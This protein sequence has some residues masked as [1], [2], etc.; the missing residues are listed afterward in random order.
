MTTEREFHRSPTSQLLRHI[1]DDRAPNRMTKSSR[2]DA[3]AH[4]EPSGLVMRKASRDG[5]GV[6]DGAEALVSSAAS[7]SGSALPAMLMRKFESSLDADLSSVRIHTGSDS[8]AAAHAVGARAYTIGQDIHFAAGQYDPS[9]AGGEHLLAHEV[10]H[11]V[12]QQGGSTKRQHKLEVSTPHDAAEHEADCAADA[13]VSGHSFVVT[14]GSGFQRKVFRDANS[15]AAQADSKIWIDLPATKITAVKYAY[16]TI[17]FAIKGKIGIQFSNVANNGK[18]AAAPVTG[19]TVFNSSGGGL[20]TEVDLAKQEFLH[21]LLGLK[22]LE[23][24]KEKFSFELSADQFKATVGMESRVAWEKLPWLQ[25]AFDATFYFAAVK[26]ADLQ[27]NPN[28]IKVAA[29]ESAI[30]LAGEGECRG[31]KVTSAAQLV[32][33]ASPN[34]ARIAAEAVKQGARSG[35]Q[36]AGATATT[37]AAVTGGT[38]AAL[39]AGMVETG[40]VVSAAAAIILPLAVGAAMVAGANQTGKNI[41]ASRA[42][43]AAGIKMRSE[44]DRYVSGYLDAL[45]GRRA[46]GAGATE[47][48]ATLEAYIAATGKSREQAGADLVSQNGGHDNLK[49]NLTAQLRDRLYADAVKWF[50]ATFAN[51]FGLLEKCGET[52]GMRGVFRKDLYRVL[53]GDDTSIALDTEPDPPTDDTS[54]VASLADA[55]PTG[56]DG[57]PEVGV[58]PSGQVASTDVPQQADDASFDVDSQNNDEAGSDYYA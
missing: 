34:W 31:A 48:N 57:P 35:A 7:S 49:A 51:Q 30:G 28:S 58:D 32:C 21:S 5:N 33:T 22:F 42:A 2:L 27:Q 19:G 37:T 8:A 10:A 46:T 39:V 15:D 24:A 52:W 44:V 38:D 9:S 4:P 55:T 41:V 13:M 56:Q 45:A 53:Y 54:A 36:A 26:W 20:K 50:E 40:A 1:D 23:K 12:Q 25:G 14:S 6:A 29:Y 47:G 17:D 11:T 18:A 43:I 3:P 16:V